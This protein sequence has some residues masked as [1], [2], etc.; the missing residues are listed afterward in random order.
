[1]IPSVVLKGLPF[2]GTL[3]GADEG[4]GAKYIHVLSDGTN[5]GIRKVAAELK[6][7]PEEQVVWGG[8]AGC[9]TH[10]SIKGV[11]DMAE[12]VIVSSIGE[13]SEKR[14]VGLVA[15]RALGEGLV[16]VG[17]SLVPERKIR[18]RNAEE[19][20]IVGC[21]SNLFDDALANRILDSGIK[22]VELVFS[23]NGKPN[24]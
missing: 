21:G 18:A 23:L 17:P 15:R 19:K 13:V 4:L 20:S 8:L 22:D 24:V 12:K 9:L 10:D 7:F 1:M 6:P 5:H 3:R 16:I 14:G 2:R 11:G